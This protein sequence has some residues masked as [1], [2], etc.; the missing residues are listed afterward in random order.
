MPDRFAKRVVSAI[1]AAEGMA[2]GG[3]MVLTDREREIL[4]CAAAGQ[5][6]EL[7][8]HAGYDHGYFFIAS[9]VADHIEHHARTLCA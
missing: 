8:R 5:P 7:R 6:L 3:V 9:F 4:A 2:E 1:I